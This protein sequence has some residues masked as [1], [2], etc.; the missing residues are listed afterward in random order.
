MEQFKRISTSRCPLVSFFNLNSNIMNR[1]YYR[2]QGVFYLS[3]D[4]SNQ[5]MADALIKTF[6][7]RRYHHLIVDVT[8]ASNPRQLII[9]SNN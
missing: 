4:A 6:I 2:I 3:T 8:D 1:Y 5:T 9:F 7:D